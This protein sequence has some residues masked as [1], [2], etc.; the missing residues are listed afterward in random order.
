MT[1]D[2]VLEL[3]LRNFP[4]QRTVGQQ[5]L[6]VKL[7]QFIAT[8]QERQLMVIRG[9]AGTGKTTVMGALVRTLPTLKLKSVLL[10]PTGRAAKVL[11]NY[12]GKPAY[13]IHKKIY[14]R[15]SSAGSY[16]TFNLNDNLHTYTIFVI[17]EA[18]M[19]SSAGGVAASMYEYR[20]LLEDLMDYVYS[21]RKCKLI[22]VGDNAQLP[23]VNY[24]VSPAL[25]ANLLQRKYFVNLDFI[26]LTDVV[27]QGADSGVLYNATALRQQIRNERFDWPQFELKGFPDIFRITGAELQDELEAAYNQYSPEEVA[28]ICR[29][30]KRANLFNQQVRSRIL[31]FEDEIAAGDLMMV[32]RNNYF[33]LD[34]DSKAG[35]IANGE[36]VEI[37]KVVGRQDLYGMRF[38]TAM[39]RL[40]DYPDEPEQE[41]KLLLDTIQVEAPSLPE[42]EHKKF[43]H[44]VAEDYLEEFPDRRRRHQEILKNEYFQALQVKFAY[45]VTCHKAQGG[46]W[47]V[48]FVD[49][50]YLTEEMINV[51]FLRWLYTALTRST[52]RLYLVNF[53]QQ[54]FL[55]ES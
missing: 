11:S 53:N 29:S 27:R 48:V 39:V 35:F 55:N 20:D 7:A 17:D 33:W 51:E 9:Y 38:A 26:E 6:M 14:R 22:M 25:D 10:A 18:S 24:D 23:P 8:D 40:I 47:P 44:T 45:A 1:T 15:S 19:I 54:F 32:V 4:F 31:W 16:A 52:E 49:Q 37:M 43:Y 30:N 36:I 5:E 21:G 12:S 13:T 50:G 46:Q 34:E 3:L 2:R 41:V 42:A 28:V